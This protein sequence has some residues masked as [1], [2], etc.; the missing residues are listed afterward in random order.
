M[1]TVTYLPTDNDS[2]LFTSNRDE[3]PSRAAS[4]IQSRAINGKQVFFP[5]DELAQGTWI[6][7][8]NNHQLVC[9]LNGAFVVHQ[10]NPPYRMSRGL[11]A[12]QFFEYANADH[13]FYDFQFEGLEP[14]TFI[15]Y[16]QGKLY[17]LHWDENDPNV[18]ELAI[19][20]PHI[21]SSATLYEPERQQQRA[22]WFAQW[23]QKQATFESQNIL[24]FHQ[25]AGEGD[26]AYNLVMNRFG[27]VQ[28]TSITH[29]QQS[30][31]S[32]R[33]EYFN[34]LHGTKDK[35]VV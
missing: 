18:R 14:F 13:F 22:Q 19:D 11:M 25:N 17:D 20:Q 26:P 30:P 2:F 10:R 24:D 1:C 15:I 9:I 23:Q 21:W 34:L 3:A 6:A 33:M 27:I 28:T 29:L 32:I 12:L 35:L 16:D 31:D 5:Q 4:G 7:S 8:S